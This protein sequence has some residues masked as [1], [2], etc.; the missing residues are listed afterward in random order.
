MFEKI[1]K[2]IALSTESADIMTKFTVELL[3]LAD[4]YGVD[5]DEHIRDICASF[6]SVCHSRSFKDFK[7]DEGED[8]E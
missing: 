7:I 6:T 5:R 3:K 2:R 8:E 1:L 4:K